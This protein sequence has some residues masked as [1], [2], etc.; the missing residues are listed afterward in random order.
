MHSFVPRENKGLK[1]LEFL[2]VDAE[3]RT[4]T[5]S[6]A[7]LNFYIDDFLWHESRGPGKY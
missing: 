5:E 1:A 6:L 3:L 2:S 7:F 4:E